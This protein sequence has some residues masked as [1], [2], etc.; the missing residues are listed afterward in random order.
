V[1]V[2]VE[3]SAPNVPAEQNVHCER[4]VAPA[5]TVDL[6]RGQGIQAVAP[7][8]G[9]YEPNGQLNRTKKDHVGITY[10]YSAI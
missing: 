8:D 2:F 5:A 1:N 6:P 7:L 9:L 4:E 10:V 3:A